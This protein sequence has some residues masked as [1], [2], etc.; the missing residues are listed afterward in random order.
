MYDPSFLI[1]TQRGFA[2]W[3]LADYLVIPPNKDGIEVK[4]NIP[5]QE[6]TIAETMDKKGELIGR[7]VVKWGENGEGKCHQVGSVIR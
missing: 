3:E 2:K 7:W 6:E 5:G 1:E 4:N